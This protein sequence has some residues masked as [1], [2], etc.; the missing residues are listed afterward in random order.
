[1]GLTEVAWHHRGGGGGRCVEWQ[2]AAGQL[3]WSPA[4]KKR[5]VRLATHQGFL[6]NREGG[7]GVT[8]ADES[9]KNPPQWHCSPRWGTIG[10]VVVSVGLNGEGVARGHGG[11]HPP[12]SG[13]SMGRL[14]R[15]G[16]RSAR[17]RVRRLWRRKA[18][19]RGLIE[20]KT[21]QRG[22]V[23]GAGDATWRQGENGAQH[24][25]SCV[26]VIETGAGRAVFSTMREQGSGRRTWA[27]QGRK[28][29]GRA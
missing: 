4:E 24:P 14:V 7:Q 21:K 27:G 2:R 3:R 22:G 12:R 28:E 19:V 11:G 15:C 6:S 16:G 25:G 29:L 13:S 23:S 1:M 20:R 18:S 26:G 9:M 17:A 5:S 10:N 8:R